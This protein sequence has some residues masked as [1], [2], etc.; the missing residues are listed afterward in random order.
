MEMAEGRAER[1]QGTGSGTGGRGQGDGG[2]TH[3][4]S[5]AAL[6]ADGCQVA[7]DQLGGLGLPRAALPAETQRGG[8]P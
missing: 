5:S 8:T 2:S 1:G 7:Q 6:L 4:L 3:L